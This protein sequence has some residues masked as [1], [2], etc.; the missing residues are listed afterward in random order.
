MVVKQIMEARGMA[1]EAPR[2]DGGRERGGEIVQKGG[3]IHLGEVLERK[4]EGKGREKQTL[5][6]R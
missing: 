3:K 6:E 4:L 1:V 2:E 5:Y